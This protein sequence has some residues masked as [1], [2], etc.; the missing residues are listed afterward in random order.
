M[1]SQGRQRIA[2]PLTRYSGVLHEK[3]TMDT[4]G[5]HQHSTEA[6]DVLIVDGGSVLLFRLLTQRARR[7]VDDWVREDRLLFSDGLAVEHRYVAAVVA[8]IEAD[9]L[10][11]AVQ[12]AL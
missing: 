7:W 5:H 10:E 6:T 9:N 8:G 3:G 11:L 4:S 12:G 2:Q 1:W